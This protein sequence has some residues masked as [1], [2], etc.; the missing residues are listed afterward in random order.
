VIDAGE[1]EKERQSVQATM[2]SDKV[3]DVARFPK[4]AF[5]SKSVSSAK[6][7]LSGWD[8]SLTGILQFHGVER[9]VSFPVHVRA[10]GSLLEAQGEVSLL[11]TEYGITPVRIGGGAV[12][13]KNRVKIS[14][15]LV[16]ITANR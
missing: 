5:S 15:T 7:T 10:Q 16:A 1:S 4:I 3:L 11:Q 13:V 2:N 14:F 6:K 12:K 8:L 9:Q